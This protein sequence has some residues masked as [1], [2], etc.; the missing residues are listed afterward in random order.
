[1]LVNESGLVGMGWIGMDPWVMTNNIN[2][3]SRFRFFSSFMKSF[4]YLIFI[5]TPVIWQQIN[6]IQ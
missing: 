1:M 6:H 5:S 3:P 4:L 2:M